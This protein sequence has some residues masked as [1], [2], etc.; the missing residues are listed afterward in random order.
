LVSQRGHMQRKELG[1]A[2]RITSALARLDETATNYERK[3]SV[4]RLR[5]YEDAAKV[6]QRQMVPNFKKSF[7]RAVRTARR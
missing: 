2:Q 3:W 7:E 5:F 4:E 6:V 1:D